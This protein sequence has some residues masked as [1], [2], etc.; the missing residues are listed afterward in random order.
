MNDLSR[1]PLDHFMELKLFDNNAKNGY[2]I[3][4]NKS[5]IKQHFVTFFKYPFKCLKTKY[6]IDG[7][8]YEFDREKV[9]KQRLAIYYYQMVDESFADYHPLLSLDRFKSM[10][11]FTSSQN[12]Y[13]W[14]H[15][16]N[17]DRIWFGKGSIQLAGSMIT[18]STSLPAPFSQ[19][20]HYSGTKFRSKDECV[21]SCLYEGIGRKESFRQIIHYSPF[22]TIKLKE[23]DRE[24]Q[25]SSKKCESKCP[26]ACQLTHFEWKNSGNDIDKRE[27]TGYANRHVYFTTRIIYSPAFPLVDYI[28]YLA[29]IHGLWFGLSICDIG[30]D[31]VE[32][33]VNI[34]KEAFK[35]S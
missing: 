28:I 23:N 35:A 5:E 7:Q 10:Y 33:I 34:K 20:L 26:T 1:D 15:K 11:I 13:P 27:L 4:S 16:L 25:Q 2:N 6:R 32:I 19:Y 21:D 22:K 24:F 31:L 3:T 12:Q 30:F 9:L 29:G 8:V 17:D 18:E 14:S